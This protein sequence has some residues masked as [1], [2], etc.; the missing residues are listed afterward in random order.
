MG[1]FLSKCSNY[2]KLKFLK[3]FSPIPKRFDGKC[4]SYIYSS[5][6]SKELKQHWFRLP[7]GCE[8]TM[9][10]MYAYLIAHHVYCVG[11]KKTHHLFF[12]FM[13]GV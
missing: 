6:K 1:R 8:L 7:Q 3:L 5:I 11:T 12:K 2:R 10:S 4:N 9:F 13:V